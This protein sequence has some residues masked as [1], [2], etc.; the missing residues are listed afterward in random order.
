MLRHLAI[1]LGIA[2]LRY[3]LTLTV[4]FWASVAFYLCC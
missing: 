1:S 4:A 3:P 2:A